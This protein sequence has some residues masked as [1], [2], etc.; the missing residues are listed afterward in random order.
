MTLHKSL[1]PAAVAL[2]IAAA[3]AAHAAIMFQGV[4][5]TFEQTN[6]TTLTFEIQNATDDWAGVGF[7][8]AFDLKDLGENFTTTTA[9]LNGPGVTNLVGTNSQLSAS[10]VDCGTTTG[11]T[12]SVCFDLGD[13]A[14]TP[15]M[16]YT[17]SFSSPLDISATGPHLQIA[18]SDTQGGSK[19]GSLF[20][21]DVGLGTTSGGPGTTSGG[22]GT[23]TGGP[24]TTTG[25]A[26]P[27]PGTLAL[28]AGALIGIAARRR[29]KR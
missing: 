24:G 3:P 29:F 8:S 18:F 1:Y 15:D 7:L 25:G 19:V 20:S 26:V 4:T 2:L 10:N 28:L 13:V 11:Q 12:G 22:P 5:F 6:D 21:E 16:L 9:T 17:I 23:T 14:L 27:E